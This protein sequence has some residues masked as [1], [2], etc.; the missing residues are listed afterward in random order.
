M[1][2]FS[3]KILSLILVIALFAALPG[4]AAGAASLT[5]ET[6]TIT[7]GIKIDVDGKE[8]VPV[9]SENAAVDV[10][11]YKGTTYL[12]IRGISNLFGLGIE[13]DDASKSVYLGTRSGVELPK[14]SGVAAETTS[15]FAQESR[16]IPV[17][18]GVTIYFNDEEFVPTGSEGE[19]VK[20]FI[21]K[22]TTYVPVRAISRLM[23]AAIDWNQETRTVL[24]SMGSDNSETVVA[25]AKAAAELYTDMSSILIPHYQYYLNVA[26]VLAEYARLVKDSY[27]S[28]NEQSAM[29]YM[30]FTTAYNGFDNHFGTYMEKAISFYEYAK[31]FTKDIEKYAEGGYTAEELEKLATAT[32]YLMSNQPYYSDYIT[33]STP[34]LILD[35]VKDAFAR[36]NDTVTKMI[37]DVAAIPVI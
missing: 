18:T 23:N 9:D 11:L 21:Y 28:T 16:N 30:M 8:F 31:D 33:G 4:M 5:T 3:I 34:A 29:E 27:V 24:L 37:D 6:I 17:Y 35:Y 7:G 22:G 13:W 19:V 15:P 12:P 1:K 2:K 32:D 20:V 36:I 25:E 26:S 10:F 14:Y